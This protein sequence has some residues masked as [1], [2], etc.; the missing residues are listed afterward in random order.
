MNHK[1]AEGA[2]AIGTGLISVALMM[3][4]SGTT[5]AQYGAPPP[6]GPSPMQELARQAAT[7]KIEA[8]ESEVEQNPSLLN[9][10]QYLAAHPH[11][12]K[13]VS[14]HPEATQLIQQNPASFL[15]H[16][17]PSTGLPPRNPLPTNTG[18]PCIR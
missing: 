7:D 3:S 18:D 10:P 15:Q 8:V 11:L 9:D 14:E 4:L 13:F 6:G 5:V 12:A 16:S 2:R 17:M 1:I